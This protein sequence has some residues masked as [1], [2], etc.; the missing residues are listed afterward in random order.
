MVDAISIVHKCHTPIKH[1]TGLRMKVQS[2][3]VQE[4]LLWKEPGPCCHSCPQQ[5]ALLDR[6][7][8]GSIVCFLYVLFFGGYCLFDGYSAVRRNFPTGKI[9]FKF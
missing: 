6:P 5:K 7:E 1:P 9:K 2:N 8:C 3:K 4:G